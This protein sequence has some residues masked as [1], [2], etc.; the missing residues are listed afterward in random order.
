MSQTHTD[1]D[2]TDIAG[3]MTEYGITRKS[4]DQ[5]H[6]GDYRYSN[7]RDALAEAKRSAETTKSGDDSVSA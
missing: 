1:D 5:F 7:F 2:A 4:V 3:Q 6:F